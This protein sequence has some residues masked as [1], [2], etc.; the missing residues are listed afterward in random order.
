MQTSQDCKSSELADTREFEYISEMEA[1]GIA[2]THSTSTASS[3]SASGASVNELSTHFTWQFGLQRRLHSAKQ[4]H[5]RL[6]P[7]R[8]IV[9]GQ[10]LRHTIPTTDCDILI[11]FPP[12]TQDVT[13]LSLLSH[14]RCH[15]P[16]LLVCVRHHGNTGVYA[17][18]LTASYEIFLKHASEVGIFKRLTDEYGGLLKE[19]D[20]DE[21]S[22]FQDVD[23]ACHFLTDQERQSIVRHMLFSVRADGDGHVEDVSFLHGQ[24]MFPLLLSKGIIRQVLPLHN[25]EELEYLRKHWVC[26][27]FQSQPLDKVCGYFGVKIAMYFAYLGHYT[28]ALTIPATIALLSWVVS[29]HSQ[30]VDDACFVGF[31]CV[32]V[33]WA[34]LYLE[35]WKRHSA[36]LAFHWGTLDVKDE[37][38]IEPRPLYHGELVKSAVT[39]HLEPS[40]PA[41]KRILF[42]CFVSYPL[43]LASLSLVFATM[44]AIFELQDWVNEG[45]D[46]G[47]MPFLCKYLPNILLALCIGIY[48][49]V[50]KK[51]AYWLNN[52]ENYRLEETYENNLIVKLV[53]FQFVNSFLSLFYLAFYICDVNRLRD[54]LATL[55]ITRQVVGNIREALVP[56]VIEKLKLFRIGYEMTKDVSEKVLKKQAHDIVREQKSR[57]NSSST[58]RQPESTE[59]EKEMFETGTETRETPPRVGPTLTQA[60]MEAVM[61]KF[62]LHCQGSEMMEDRKI[63]L[64][65]QTLW[66]H[67]CINGWYNP[68]DGTFDD[69]LEMFIQFGYVTLFSSAFPTAALWA[70]LNN[71]IEIRSDAFKL[72]MTLQRPFGVR[73]ANI[74]TWQR[75]LELMSIVAV[76]VNCVLIGTSDLSYR[77]FPDMSTAHRIVYIV[78]TEHVLLVMCL[79]IAHAIPDVP[80]WVAQEKARLEF[81]R[82]EAFKKIGTKKN[83]TTKAEDIKPTDC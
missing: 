35:H 34:M 64:Y 78:I 68:Y 54:Q 72:C 80:L 51:I 14:L 69:F 22:H 1:A 45:I 12:E 81:L 53:L 71:V 32:N 66:S 29:G 15:I 59:V 63:H 19:F 48:D 31:A 61:K 17:F 43:I 60:E 57:H 74:G 28:T 75:A 42:S 21:R 70:L 47:D 79:L 39:S 62:P 10:V 58:D 76:V 9:S 65:Q 5:Q 73:V 67:R 50:Y 4:L 55:L 7:S 2:R 20:Y 27:L 56:Y 37:L 77:L 8:V 23:D 36:E 82:R 3:A 38:L 25:L 11:V 49:D 52:R 46:N 24:L 6:T 16:E 30:A 33:V 41:W 13:L 26:A 44:W 83:L 40:Y 18:Y